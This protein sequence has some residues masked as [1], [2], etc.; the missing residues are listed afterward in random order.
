LIFIDVFENLLLAEIS[1]ARSG[2]DRAASD[3]T[4][5]NSWSKG[6]WCLFARQ[7][8]LVRSLRRTVVG[9]EE[10]GHAHNR[11]EAS[12]GPTKAKL[13]ESDSCSEWLIPR[14]EWFIWLAIRICM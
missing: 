3:G 4:R 9:R 5:R 14:I 10:T 6:R 13:H 12:P 7:L 1:V 8:R 2:N 11:E